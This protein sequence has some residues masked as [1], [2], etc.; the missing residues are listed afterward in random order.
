M[1]TAT[2][3]EKEAL[4][5]VRNNIGTVTEAKFVAAHGL[6][7]WRQLFAIKEW[8][9]FNEDKSVRLTDRGTMALAEVS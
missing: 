3:L 6:P 2:K 7:M 1:A 9:R 4:L 5:Y 8:I